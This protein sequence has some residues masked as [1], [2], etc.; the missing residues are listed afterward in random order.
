MLYLPKKLAKDWLLL[1]FIGENYIQGKNINLD[2]EY[3][4]LINFI[5]VSLMPIALMIIYTYTYLISP[6]S[7]AL[8]I[9]SFII[10]MIL[11]R[12]CAYCFVKHLKKHNFGDDVICIYRNLSTK[13]LVKMK[14]LSYVLRTFFI[15]YCPMWIIFALYV[16]IINSL[17]IR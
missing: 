8:G 13:D 16:I 15:C 6:I 2:C 10:L 14:S 9:F 17:P 1:R 7:H 12:G 5:T 3:S 4:I 11:L